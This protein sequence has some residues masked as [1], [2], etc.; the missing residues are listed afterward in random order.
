MMD[1]ENPDIDLLGHAG[2]ALNSVSYSKLQWSAH[3]WGWH[4]LF[5]YGSRPDF[6]LHAVKAVMYALQY[7]VFVKSL[8]KRPPIN[9][10]VLGPLFIFD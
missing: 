8:A 3:G 9:I 4:D 2:L 5:Y 1:I 6:P 7:D 10:L